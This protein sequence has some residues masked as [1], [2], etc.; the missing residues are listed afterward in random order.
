VAAVANKMSLAA[1]HGFL[2][3]IA[4]EETRHCFWRLAVNQFFT[5]N[6]ASC[7]IVH[8]CSPCIID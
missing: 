1:F 2:V 7:L 5:A 4:T 6:Q 3:G 8:Y